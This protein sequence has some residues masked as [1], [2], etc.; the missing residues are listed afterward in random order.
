MG[1]QTNLLRRNATYAWRKRLPVQLG[2]GLMQISLRTN[3][4]EIAKRVAAIVSAECTHTFDRMKTHALSKSDARH[5]LTAVIEWEL[6]RFSHAQILR[7]DDPSPTAWQIDQ[8]HNWAM[9]KALQLLMQ[10]GVSVK[11]LTDQDFATLLSEGKS[12]SD[13]EHL[14]TALGMVSQAFQHPPAEGSNA[15]AKQV[16][17]HALNRNDFNYH[18]H[19]QGRQ[20]YMGGRGAGLLSSLDIDTTATDAMDL[21]E[22]LF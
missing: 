15:R 13:F 9:G 21:A 1:L 4:P 20:I 7:A 14:Q 16:M 2:G 5:L 19:L 10:R 6:E 17:K 22:R 11:T 8:P 3:D 12:A 18:E